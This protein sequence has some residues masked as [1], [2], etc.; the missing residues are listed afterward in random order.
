MKLSMP[1]I[2]IGLT[3]LFIAAVMGGV[4]EPPPVVMIGIPG[5]AISLGIMIFC[6]WRTRT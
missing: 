4:T 3:V 6:A 1:D 2:I 5:V